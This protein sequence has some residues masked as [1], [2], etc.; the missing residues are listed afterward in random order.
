M[1]LT[2]TLLLALIFSV[3]ASAQ[4]LLFSENFET[5]SLPDSVNHTGNGNWGKSS[6]LYSQGTRSDSLKINAVGDSIMSTTFSFSTTGN[7]FVMLHFDHI[8]KI[9]FFD[10]A[11]IEVS[12]NNGSTWTRLTGAQY[13]G[14]SQFA[15]QGN[16]F[17]AAAYAIDWAAGSIAV[18]SNAWWKSEVFDIS[19]L[20]GMSSNVLIRFV[21][22]DAS[23]GNTMPDNYAWFIDNIRVVGAFSELNPP[24][25]TMTPPIPQDTMYTT[26]PYLIKANITDA[27]GIDTAYVAYTVNTGITDTIGMVEITPGN[28]QASIP[29]Y[30]FGRTIHYK[31][32]AIDGSAAYNVAYDP[33]TGTRMIYAKYS[34][35]G[36][37]TIGTA[38]TAS[39]TTGPTYISGS[40]STY[41]YSNHI[42]L[43]TPAEIG[44]TGALSK[45]SWDKADVQGY[46]LGNATYRIYL[47]HTTVSTLNTA[48]GTFATELTGATLVYENTTQSLPLS[49]G[50][51]D[52]V[53]TNPNAFSYNGT[54]NLM[55]LVYWYRP[56]TPT[57]AVTWRYST[58]T[59]RAVTWSSATDPPNIT[60]GSGSRP[61]ITM[62]FVTPSNL[63]ADAGI[64]QI[65]YPT[66]GVIANT[67]FNVVAKVKNYG[68]DT[69]TSATVNW[70]L[71]GVLQAPYSW[72]GSLLQN[73]LSSD[74]TLGNITLPLGVHEIK[75]WTDNPN[76]IGDMNFGNDTMK[77]S[78]MACASL[79]SGAYTIGGTNPDFAD[80][81][82]A[83]IALDQCGISAP[84]TFNVASGTYTNQVIVPFVSGASATNPVIFQSAT[85]DSTD[86]I[87]QYSA[88][89]AGANYTLKFDSTNY[90]TFRKMTIKALNTSN[91]R[92][93]E[94]AS[95]SSNIYLA[96]NILSGAVNA[97]KSTSALHAVVFS[98]GNQN[99]HIKLENNRILD[100]EHGIWLKGAATAKSAGTLVTG[101]YFAGQTNS[102]MTLTDHTAPVVTKNHIHSTN[103]VDV[104]RGIYVVNS[105]GDISVLANNVVIQNAVSAHGIELAGCVSAS[106]APGM[107]ANNMVSVSINLSGTNTMYPC[108]LIAYNSSYQR[109]YYN[110]VN[111]YGNSNQ[112]NAAF[113]FYNNASHTGIDLLNN[114]LVNHVTGGVILNFEGVQPAA[115]TS[116]YNNLYAEDGGTAFL[117]SGYGTLAAWQG[118]S[119]RDLNSFAIKPYFNS[120]TDLHTYN[121]MLNGLATPVASVTHDFDGDTRDPVNPDPGADEFDPPAIDVTLLDI[122]APAGGC[123][124]TST[125]PVTVLIKNVG[126]DTIAGGLAG[127]FRFNNS[128]T[129]VSESISATIL[130]GDTLPYTFTATIN[131]DVS[132]FG[133]ID[134][135]FAL[136][137]WTTL[138][139]DFVPFNDT[140]KTQITSNY[141]PP[142]P[143]VVSPVNIPYGSFAVL[144]ATSSNTIEWFA[145]D[146]SSVPL[147]T[148]LIFTTPYLYDT[149]F[150]WVQA[151]AGSVG[152]GA[153]IALNAVAAHSGGGATTYGPQNYNDGIIP[154][155]TVLPWGWVTTNGWIEY[156]WATPVTFNSVKFYKD[157]RPM[158]S[159]T[160]QYW[161]GSA[162]VDFLSYSSA[163][164]DDSVSFP[165]VT[166]TRLRFFTVA[167]SSNP[168]F[169]EIQV[170][171]PKLSGCPSYRVPV[172]VNTGLPPTNDAGISEIVQPFGSTASGVPT[173]VIVRLKNFGVDTL[174]NAKIIWSLNSVIQ[175][176]VHWTG[177]LPYSLTEDVTVDTLTFA[178]G[179]YCIQAWTILPNG[180]T[181]SVNSNDTASGCFNACMAG[182]YSI[183]PAAGG[184]YNYNTFNSALN[185]LIASG[186]CGHVV[187]EVHPGTYNEQLTIPAIN[188]MDANNTVTFRS[189]TGDSTSVTLQYTSSSTTD[190]WTVRLNGADWFRFERLTIRALNATNGRVVELINGAD[191]NRF[192]GT[193]LITA[194]AS[195]TTTSC[196][197]DGSTLNHYNT[198]LNN[199]M[200]GGYYTM[201][202]Y[203]IS[204][205]SWQK[206]TVIQGN[207]IVGSY[208]YP[209]Y[210]YYTDST[211]IIGNYIHSNVAPYS[212][213]IS[214]YYIN[215]KY[216]IVGNRISIIGSGS[217]VSY[218]LR[219][220]Y[221]NYFS[222]NANPTGY[223]LVANNMISISGSTGGHYG[224][225]AY[226]SNG[227]EYYYN[228]VSLTG[229][230]S[231]YYALYQY[232]T[233]SNPLG[234]KFVNNIFSNTAGGYAAYYGTPAS[235]MVCDYNNYYTSASN[236]VYWGAAY[237]NLA[238]L[239]TASGKDANSHNINPPFSSTHDLHLANTLLSA[240]AT[241]L[242][243]ITTD[244]DGDPRSLLPTIGADEIPLLANDAGV[245]AISS[246]G[247]LTN[248]GQTYPV[249]VTVANFGTDPIYTM[250]IVYSVN[251][252][253]PITYQYN[254]TL[255]S[256][257]TAVV[258]LPSMISPAGN[259]VICAK[260]ILLNDTNYFNDQFCKNFFGTPLY[261]AYVTR[262]VGLEEDGCNLGLDTVSIW[263]KNIGVNP[264]NAP[265]PNTVTAKYQVGN[266][267]V[268]SQN[269]TPVIQPQDSVL[270]H[271]TTLVDFSVTTTT[272]TFNVVAWIDLVGDNVKYNDTATYDV[273]SRH[274]PGPPVVVDDTIPYGTSV[275]LY[276][277]SPDS[278]YWFNSATAQTEFHI[279]ASYTTP[280]LY[281]NTTYWVQAGTSSFS[282][283]SLYTGTQVSNYAAAQTRGYHFTAPCD[284]TITELMVP[285]TVT[286]GTQ[287]IQVVKFQGYPLVYPSASPHTT[288]AFIANA[289]FGV[290]QQVNIP[291]MAGDEIGIIGATNSTGT[292]MNNSYGG[293]LVPSSINGNPVTLTRL[294]YQSPLV[295]GQA[296]TGTISIEVSSSIARVEMKY[297]VGSPG[298]ASTRVPLN[299][300]VA[301]QQACDLGVSTIL[302]PVTAVNLGS[303]E[304]VRV[305]ITNYG[306]QAQS[307]FPV[308]FQV[309][310]NPPVTETVTTSV[311]SNG[312]I[313]YNFV[314]KANLGLVGNTYQIKAWTGLSCDNTH[315]NDTAWKTVQNLF[316]SYC[317]STATSTGYEDLTNVTL[318]TL[319]NTSAAVG[320][321]YTN[322]SAT[323]PPP[324]LS[325]GMSYPI[326][327]SSGFPPSYSYQ[328]NCWVKVWIDFNRDGT[329]DPV[330]EMIF[331][332]ATTSSNTV[333]GNV[334]IPPTAMSGNTLMR[335][336][337]VETSAATSVNP[338]GTYTWGETEDY[339]ITIS[340]QGACD[341]GIT[342][343]VE[344]GG[345]TAAGTS[346]PIKVVVMNFGSD[347]IAPGTLSIAYKINNGT[348]VIV[349]YPGGLPSMGK[350]TVTLGNMTANLG[351]NDLCVYVILACDTITFNDEK[352][353]TVFGN[354]ATN[355]PYFDDFEGPNYWYKPDASTNWQ[356]GT[357]AANIIN[358]AY[359]GTK[360]WVTKLAGNYTDNANDYL[361]SPIFDFSGLSGV[362]TVTMSFYHWQDMQSGDYGRVQYS[363]DGGSNWSNLGFYQDGFGVNW[364]NVTSG[365]LHYFSTLN[366]GWQ[367][368]AYKL[369]PGTFNIHSDVRF[370][371]NFV[372]N[373]SGNG[374]GWAIDNFKLSLPMVPNDVGV[375][376]ITY[377]IN[378]TAIG[379]VV[380][381]KVTITNFGSNPQVMFPVVLKL[382]GAVVATETWTGSLPSL[383]T[384]SYTFIQPFTVPS[385]NY[386]LCA[387][388]QLSGDAF[389]VNNG[390]CQNFAPQPAYHD[391][392]V[393]MIVQP[394]PDSAG[395]ICF[396]HAQAQPW[397]QYQVIVRLH[398]PGQYTQT[399]I[400]VK[401]T[402]STGGTV[403]TD[404]WTGS[405]AHT[406]TVDLVLTDLFLP[407][408]GAQQLCVETDLSGDPVTTNNKTCKSYTGKACIGIDNP[409]GSAFELYQNIPNPASKT[410][411]IGYRVPS[412]GDVTFGLVSLLGQVM[413]NEV[414]AVTAGEHQF[415]LHVSS[416]AAGVYYYFVEFNGQRLTK[417]LVI[418]NI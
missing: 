109:F 48:V 135:T 89:S 290:P 258:T 184:T 386:Q 363:I 141:T 21:L 374:N 123:G 350:D 111:V 280:I 254:D 248:E 190:N 44:F 25:I 168:N 282:D 175:D 194:G 352:C 381:P 156:T 281:S 226:Y 253:A 383:G 345:T 10:E 289:P 212:Y 185:T 393:A 351:Y 88:T 170:F 349:P 247:I 279:G 298:C 120:L 222:Y 39:S 213:G 262:I 389:A 23:V 242:A 202:I 377:P 182:T 411:T 413:H 364:Y 33:P 61:N 232:N 159:C 269:F 162:Y 146:T 369:M 34:P 27:S 326:S 79:L 315:Q 106:T 321:M 283:S 256:A 94:I 415:E 3:G 152:S 366:T 244:I 52:F 306:T 64:G 70:T 24:V 125:Q 338:C 417:K 46:T 77:I 179:I 32:I 164:I 51:L 257:A 214:A 288:L 295:S 145:T 189:F 57:G 78:F 305:R 7:S 203:G 399:S 286:Q 287:Y 117:T 398:N 230:S 38:T 178:G 29:F 336:V 317:I 236:F 191:Y 126:T 356:Y 174:F 292:T 277:Q 400:P 331:S 211:Q 53:L 150:F 6:A 407:A 408:L 166:S 121:G 261:D 385:A 60:Y 416:L 285:T 266:Q 13:Q 382:N 347:P 80:F 105:D 165:A 71:D 233:T 188:G 107:V 206:G 320:S 4:T 49:T 384:T 348:P 353:V 314:A 396:Y 362:D 172:Q 406:A 63:P 378:D 391:V 308:S 91:G 66:G 90:V 177:T 31:V 307:N 358:T 270:F 76:G 97:P 300:I 333:T 140:V 278:V 55:V 322:F 176:T 128:A 209:M 260:T 92:A 221:G 151:R 410:T 337:F 67:S 328:Y 116:N 387:E 153:N 312:F 173:Q 195:S 251:N 19:L 35:G 98:G 310:S 136:A 255:S 354:Y 42:S 264:I 110:S 245:I 102:A 346:H 199:Y 192:E 147:D 274:T 5:N 332:S 330:N 11:Y 405:L 341:A 75:I 325:P 215:N 30:G 40:T 187:F 143:V 263:V 309:G 181:D 59:G 15:T 101:N 118:Y 20:V 99:N 234:Q 340:P 154:A 207:E 360:S 368:S 83:M 401:Y 56:G 62:T 252:G 394:Q 246:P 335:V 208:Y 22:K 96:N 18:P 37:V 205:S 82:A 131:L 8:C 267:P 124:M 95:T 291:V 93:V 169:R 167:G 204:T 237:P 217:S 228:S 235:V 186:I 149:T 296:A 311:P 119:G 318:H 402:F 239:Q 388:T 86:V 36:T 65:V 144:S 114:N 339:M 69:L 313:D 2:I 403:H 249:T 301:N 200:E 342:A 180:V 329:F 343:I 47:K 327:I 14:I 58:S 129:V 412:G 183:G 163:V 148:G 319:N 171:E 137:A 122:I 108:G 361:Y 316:P 26:D 81:S 238:A 303:Q 218:G 273:I 375:S 132:A 370:R 241:P 100:G 210:V 43:F 357:P 84:V 41:L 265:S 158:T 225:Y 113:R 367:Y 138:T 72:T 197:Y 297:Q 201:Y 45:I 12:N 397:Y 268:V 85:G 344:P 365:G 68:T 409:A 373:T 275:T 324:V 376:A 272:D 219:D 73:A 404:T 74:I 216:R 17:T 418:S 224:L 240:K 28:F 302:E 231:T 304:N 139:G 392:G 390:K 323:V 115:F 223:G 334:S 1:R 380:Y 16:K 276:A 9:E 293:T 294:V 355:V 127:H 414:Q 193:R 160:F 155:Y 130:P 243:A 372:S 103:L 259:S 196:V 371:F 133:G 54:D 359:S 198:Y 271:F 112:P 284:M 142:A 229:G 299:V 87:L 379:S 134:S 50:W 227:T 395:N 104:Y 157:N 161:N 220:Y 250:D